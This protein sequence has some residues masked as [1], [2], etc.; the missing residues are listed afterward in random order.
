MSGPLYALKGLAAKFAL[1]SSTPE[2]DTAQTAQA[3]ASQAHDPSFTQGWRGY[4]DSALGGLVGAVKDEFGIG[5]QAAARRAD[6]LG[7]I[8]AHPAAI[9]GTLAPGEAGLPGMYSRVDRTAQALPESIHPSKAAG[10]FKNLAS[11]EEVDYRG[12]GD[13]LAGQ[14]GSQV[15]KADIQ[16]HLAAHPMP[17]LGVKDLGGGTPTGPEQYDGAGGLVTPGMHEPTMHGQGNLQVPGGENYRERLLTLPTKPWQDTDFTEESFHDWHKKKYGSDIFED[18]PGYFTARQSY[19]NEVAPQPFQSSHWEDPNVLAHTRFN[20]RTL[21]GPENLPTPPSHMSDWTPQDYTNNTA[22]EGSKGRFLEEVQS[23]W[24]QKGKEEGYQT[25]TRPS[26]MQLDVAYSDFANELHHGA[27]EDAPATLA[28]YQ[29]W[30]DLR[31]QYEDGG[32]GVPNAPFKE[33]WPDLALKQHVLDVSARPDLNWLGFTTGAT[34]NERYN[35]AQRVHSLHYDPTPTD[36]NR[37]GQLT[38]HYPPELHRDPDLFGL[39]SQADLHNYLGH[40]L[41]NHLL[42]TTPI[43]YMNLDQEGIHNFHQN[44]PSMNAEHGTFDPTTDAHMLAGS[45]LQMPGKGMKTFYDQKLPSALNKILKPFGGTVEKGTIPGPPAEFQTPTPRRVFR[46]DPNVDIPETATHDE[47]RGFIQNQ[48]YE[49]RVLHRPAPDQVTE[50]IASAWPLTPAGPGAIVDAR[51]NAHDLV[52][53][54][55]KQPHLQSPGIPAWIAHLPPAMKEAILNKGLPLL[56]LLGLTQTPPPSNPS[57]SLGGL[58]AAQ[59]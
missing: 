19:L 5:E 29:R 34:Q 37:G 31:R 8:T 56:T 3:E 28:A 15:K 42:N 36:I 51:M 18:Q 14:Q 35:L 30:E 13:F 2:E 39:D 23:D 58:K 22:A 57:D 52:N 6:P 38:V 1:P 12:L 16:G 49:G 40:E 59:Q 46:G 55:A 41:T 54:M 33:S 44:F 47:V 7:Y 32:K 11:K 53:L 27:G 9:A 25:G 21:P 48:P 24:H 50:H 4:V 17:E 10:V 45:D 43:A 26:A 20:E